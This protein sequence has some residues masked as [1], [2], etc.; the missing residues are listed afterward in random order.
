LEDN[1]KDLIF[2]AGG[3]G[4]TPFRSIIK[5]QLNNN[6]KM[7]I[8]LLYGCRTEESIIFKKEL[9]NIKEKWFNMKCFLSHEKSSS[10][11]YKEG[12]ISKE[13]IKKNIKDLN[14]AYFYICGPE[15]MKDAIKKLLSEL[16]VKK[17][18][19]FIEDFFW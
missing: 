7:N 13:D 11:K 4:I 6:D 15:P 12:Y 2:F 8:A 9:E 18:N 1:D 17:S 14:N 5:N 10:K 19:I 16:N 3:V